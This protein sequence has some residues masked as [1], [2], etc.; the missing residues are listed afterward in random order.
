MHVVILTQ[1]YP[2]ETGAPQ[3]RLHA[4]SSSLIA[5]GHEVT[6]LTGMPNYPVMEIQPEYRGKLFSSEE[7]DGVKICRSWLY[8]SKSK[9]L[10]SRMLNYLTFS[11]T[12]FWLGLFRL[13]KADI[14]VLESPPL[15]L[16]FSAMPLSRL[17]GMKLVSNISDLWPESAV[18]LGLV[19]N[20]MAIKM[21]AHLERRMYSRSVLISG[22]TQ[23]IVKN[24][25]SRFPA[26]RVV[27]FPNGADLE[28][29]TSLS[30]KGDW[31][32]K[33]RLGDFDFVA[34]YAGVIGHAQGLDVILEAAK[35]IGTE[36]KCAFVIVGHGPE[37]E[38]LTAKSQ[39]MGLNNV[40]FTGALNK[41]EMKELLPWFD[42][43]IV[44]LRKSPLF[45]GA[46]PSKIFENLAAQVPVV[47]GVE[48]EAEE[49]F[50]EQG[51]C[52][53]KFEPENSH[54][55][56]ELILK[57]EASADLRKELKENGRSY[58]EKH[59]NRVEVNGS[60]VKLLEEL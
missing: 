9:G 8:V 41:T 15:F 51:K 47:L 52:A 16:A 55:L 3:N 43:S 58:V 10:F 18:A 56:A 19:K 30:R 14:L 49:L 23:G 57:L 12:S 53:L 54:Q 20:E 44:P 7:M 13:R 48:G 46:I 36:R 21:A 2:P 5:R 60:F 27:W 1:Y 39:E 37:R 6:V 29:W 26:K 34:G 33:L 32:H 50:I 40:I 38:R 45:L 42:C 11:F 25:E 24:I 31:S 59:F 4:L 22:Q 28:K 17:K 35:L